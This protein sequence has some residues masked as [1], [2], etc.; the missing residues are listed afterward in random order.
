MFLM[1]VWGGGIKDIHLETSHPFSDFNVPSG[2]CL[3]QNQLE[4]S[5]PLCLASTSQ[6]FCLV[7]GLCLSN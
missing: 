1:C 2:K 5:L 3:L 7:P 4:V 6:G